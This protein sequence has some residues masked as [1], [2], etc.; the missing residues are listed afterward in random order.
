MGPYVLVSLPQ[1]RWVFVTARLFAVYFMA[2]KI[3]EFHMM[4]FLKVLI[5]F[6]VNTLFF[7]TFLIVQLDWVPHPNNEDRMTHWVA[8][9]FD[10]VSCAQPGGQVKTFVVI[11]M[12][13]HLKP[14]LHKRLCILKSE[15]FDWRARQVGKG[16]EDMS[17]TPLRQHKRGSY[18][19]WLQSLCQDGRWRHRNPCKLVGQL[20]WCAL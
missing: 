18:S 10:E 2:L 9:K 4:W 12:S 7:V 16:H 13:I 11:W 6:E 17:S 14:P 19:A 5:D 3:G 20:A 1:N 15:I 8:W